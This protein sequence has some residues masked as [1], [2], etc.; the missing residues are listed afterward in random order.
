MTRLKL[1]L[2]A[3]GAFLFAV[4]TFGQLKKREGRADERADQAQNTLERLEE[5]RDA[6]SD[7]RR[8]NSGLA[9]QLRK[10]DSQW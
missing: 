8:S 2:A 5:G 7:A 3:A 6:V 10:N 4:F 1:W 9:D